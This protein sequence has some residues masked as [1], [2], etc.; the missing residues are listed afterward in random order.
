MKFAEFH[1]LLGIMNAIANPDKYRGESKRL[2]DT[3]M[4]NHVDLPKPV[5][6]DGQQPAQ[7]CRA[8]WVCMI[9]RKARATG[10]LAA[11]IGLKPRARIVCAHC[12]ED[13]AGCGYI[14]FAEMAG[15]TED[16]ELN[17]ICEYRAGMPS[18][19]VKME[20]L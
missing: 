20:D 16:A 8:P 11:A 18:V 10:W 4:V 9:C 1:D 17:A 15:I 2:Y 3:F 14:S 7:P 5:G 12:A 19:A 13:V 6:M